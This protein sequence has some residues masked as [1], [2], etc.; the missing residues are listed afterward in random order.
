MIPH[1]I[2]SMTS[3]SD[4]HTHASPW[5]NWLYIEVIPKEMHLR[6]PK[7]AAIDS[8]A[9]CLL[10]ERCSGCFVELHATEAA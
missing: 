8:V 10:A 7:A 1:C 5:F 2:C 6:A 9:A 4:A 3:Y